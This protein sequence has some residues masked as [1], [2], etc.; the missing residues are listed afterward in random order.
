MSELAV[1]NLRVCLDARLIGGTA[2]G[3]E[4]FIV[5]LAQGLSHLNDG[6][7]TYHFLVYEGA[8]DWLKPH[9][10]GPCQ[11]LYGPSR[12]R[13]TNLMQLFRMHTPSAY[14]LWRRIY[15]VSE[16]WNF[17]M[18]WSDGTIEKA[19]I[20]LM[21]QTIPWGFLTRVPCIYHPHDLQHLNLP[22][23][24]SLSQR[25]IREVI[26]RTLCMQAKLVAVVS[27]W[28]KNNVIEHYHLP[29]SKVQVI[30][31]APVT[32][33]AVPDQTLC[34]QVREKYG[35]PDAF[36]FYPAQTWMHKN[37]QRLLEALAILRDRY[38]LT[39]PFVSSGR[40]YEAFFPQIEKKVQELN[41]TEQVRFLGHVSLEELQSLYRLC[42]CV[43]IPTLSEA[44]SFPLWEAFLAGAPAACSNVTSLPA[45]AGDAALVFDPHQPA[46]IAEAIR[47]LWSDA[48]LRQVLVERGRKNVAR[49]SWDRTARMFRAHYRRIARRPLTEEDRALLAAPPLL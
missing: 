34:E 9:L 4:Q 44:G 33:T 40:R 26:F 27:S 13:E 42:R 15:P 20:D 32:G 7:E 24:F 18:L 10:A 19:G 1:S 47:R 38:G 39:V 37:H 3:V 2:G 35:L 45:Q 31:Y 6:D 17:K 46:E 41:L 48:S 5:G 25:L 16:R 23:N 14:T 28:V 22:Q 43:V 12:P 30:P 36:I 49:F 21:H 11:A 8:D 29:D